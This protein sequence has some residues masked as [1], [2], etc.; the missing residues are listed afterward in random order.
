MLSNIEA[1][2]SIGA[3]SGMIS[4]VNRS[5][6]FCSPTNIDMSTDSRQ[7]GLTVGPYRHLLGNNAIDANPGRGMDNDPIRMIDQQAPTNVT[8]ERDFGAG[9]DTPEPVAEDEIFA[10]QHR[11]QSG[12]VTPILISAD[13]QEELSAGIPKSVRSLAIPIGEFSANPLTIIARFGHNRKIPNWCLTRDSYHL[14]ADDPSESS[15]NPP[16][17]T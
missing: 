11:K 4:N 7:S 2:G 10:G 8:T 16:L 14:E 5:E 3:D 9:H 17:P 12:F 13:R 15:Q 6:D 1:A